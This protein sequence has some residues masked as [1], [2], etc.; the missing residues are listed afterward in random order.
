MSDTPQLLLSHVEGTYQK[1][2]TTNKTRSE[3]NIS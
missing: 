3:Q 2:Q 1:Q